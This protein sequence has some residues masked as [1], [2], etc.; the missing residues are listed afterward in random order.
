MK[1]HRSRLQLSSGTTPST[2]SHN[3]NDRYFESS[4]R[5]VFTL[6]NGYSVEIEIEKNWN[7]AIREE[8]YQHFSLIQTKSKLLVCTRFEAC[9]FISDNFFYQRVGYCYSLRTCLLRPH[10]AERFLQN[11]ELALHSLE[12]EIPRGISIPNYGRSQIL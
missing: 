8:N 5:N 6:Q 1:L 4:L 2:H 11:L 3:A 10:R 7:L 12:F 9:P